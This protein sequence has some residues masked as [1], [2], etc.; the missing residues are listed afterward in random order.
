MQKRNEESQVGGMC[1]TS[2]FTCMLAIPGRPFNSEMYVDANNKVFCLF[3][4]C[5]TMFEVTDAV[6]VYQ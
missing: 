4:L 2:C 6:Y 5:Y 3:I 1:D